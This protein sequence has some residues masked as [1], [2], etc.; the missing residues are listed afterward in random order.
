ME[1]YLMGGFSPDGNNTWSKLKY[2]HP[3]N[4]FKSNLMFETNW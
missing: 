2:V 4:L 1:M 3:S